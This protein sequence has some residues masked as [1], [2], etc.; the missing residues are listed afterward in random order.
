[1]TQ[2]TLEDVQNRLA[3][4]QRQYEELRE[5][6]QFLM[7]PSVQ[8]EIAIYQ[9][10]ER[11]LLAQAQ[12]E[13]VKL[14]SV[15]RTKRTILSDSCPSCFGLCKCSDLKKAVRHLEHPSMKIND[16]GILALL[17]HAKAYLEAQA[18]GGK[19][20][21]PDIATEKADIRRLYMTMHQNTPDM[22]AKK[23]DGK[24]E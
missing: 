16:R 21:P 3:N 7:Y 23:K 17:R 19:M 20:L 2:P 13:D 5:A 10:A 6:R 24:D 11:V 9:L 22:L 1:M 18:Q 12:C 14:Y 8:K 15:D 4:L